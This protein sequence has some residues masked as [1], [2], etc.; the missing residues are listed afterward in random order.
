MAALAGTR[1]FTNAEQSNDGAETKV[2]LTGL[3]ADA[4]KNLGAECVVECL[5]VL[6]G[7]FKAL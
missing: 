6:R 3:Q 4:D 1:I 2:V 7:I 5:D